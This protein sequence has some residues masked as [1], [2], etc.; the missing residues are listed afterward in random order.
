MKDAEGSGLVPRQQLNWKQDPGILFLGLS[1]V[2][3]LFKP[4][5]FS[6]PVLALMGFSLEMKG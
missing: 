3:Q 1:L 6:V 2:S 5:P 4:E